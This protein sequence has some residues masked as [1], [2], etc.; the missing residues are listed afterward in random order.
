ME[1]GRKRREGHLNTSK[2]YHTFCGRGPFINTHLGSGFLE[3]YQTSYRQLL[4]HIHGSSLVAYEGVNEEGIHSMC[5][6]AFLWSGNFIGLIVELL[7]DHFDWS[8]LEA[9]WRDRDVR[10][11]NILLQAGVLDKKG[12][13]SLR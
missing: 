9:V 5:G 1:R 8:D 3:F 11:G 12:T 13:N 7:I 2:R 6:L 4:W 10:L